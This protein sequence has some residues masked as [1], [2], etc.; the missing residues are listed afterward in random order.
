MWN[1]KKGFF[2]DY[3]YTTKRISGFLSLASFTPL[4]AGLATKEQAEQMVKKLPIFET[5]FG[6]V[7]TAKESL[8]PQIDLSHVPE[9]FRP[10]LQSVLEPKQWDYPNIWPPVEYLAVIGLLK[11]GYVEDA[12]RI[13]DKSIKANAALFRKYQ[14][15]LEKFNGETGDR[16]AT[17]HYDLQEGFGWTNAVFYR[18]V[19]L[20]DDLN[21]GKELY[22]QPKAEEPPFGLALLH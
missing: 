12:K 3:C 11:Y 14:T 19:H 8:A 17:F 13:M 16:A 1:D 5:D 6:L 15:F 2:F 7:I 9:R 10:A 20:L 18:Y 21:A 4:W 22:K